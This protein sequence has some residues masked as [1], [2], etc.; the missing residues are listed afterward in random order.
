MLRS[1]TSAK[2]VSFYISGS[3]ACPLTPCETS[4]SKDLGAGSALSVAQSRV[5]VTLAAQSVTTL[6]GAP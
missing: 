3:A 5:T 6:A 4:A 1:N 2:E